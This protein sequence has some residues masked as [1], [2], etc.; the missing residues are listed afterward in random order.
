MYILSFLWEFSNSIQ[1]KY[2]SGKYNPLL[3]FLPSVS[4]GQICD[5]RVESTYLRLT[6]KSG[7]TNHRSGDTIRMRIWWRRQRI[8]GS[9]VIVHVITRYD[10]LSIWCVVVGRRWNMRLTQIG[11]ISMLVI[12]LVLLLQVL[13]LALGIF[14]ASLLQFQPTEYRDNDDEHQNSQTTADNET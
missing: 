7:R 9:A 1:Y 14:D 13:F 10:E 12:Q 5:S 6:I 4:A 8:A 11:M 3:S 2:M